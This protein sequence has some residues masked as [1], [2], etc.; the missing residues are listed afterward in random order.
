MSTLCLALCEKN[1]ERNFTFSKI[2]KH[3]HKEKQQG[4][5]PTCRIG[6]SLENKITSCCYCYTLYYGKSLDGPWLT[7]ASPPPKEFG[8]A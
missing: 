5:C 6:C 4:S 1:E 2:D 8:L 3:L 7:P